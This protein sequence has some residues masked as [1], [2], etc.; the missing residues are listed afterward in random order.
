MKKIQKKSVLCKWGVA[1]ETVSSIFSVQ[2][3][4]VFEWFLKTQLLNAHI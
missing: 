1:S 3:T 4:S 2:I